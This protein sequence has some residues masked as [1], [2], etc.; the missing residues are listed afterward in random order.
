MMNLTILRWL[1]YGHRHESG[2][3]MTEFVFFLPI[4]ITVFIG[5]LNLGKVGIASTQVQ[6]QAQ[7]DL[8]AKAI[9]VSDGFQAEHMS[10][11]VAAPVTAAGY[12]ADAGETGNP[13]AGIDSLWGTLNPAFMEVRGHYGE[14]CV[15][16]KP[17]Q[18]FM[19]DGI[20]PTCS[21][22]EVLGQDDTNRYPH[23]LLNDT[24]DEVSFSGGW[25]E[26]L[27]TA[28]GMSGLIQSMAAGIRYGS[29]FGEKSET[30]EMFAGVASF[31]TSS[32]W[33]VMV[34]PRPLTGIEGDTVTFGV[35]FLAAKLDS[36]Y[37]H[38][39]QFGKTNWGGGDGTADTP[40]ADTGDI[41]DQTEE[42]I[43]EQCDS[44]P[45]YDDDPDDNPDTPP[46]PKTP[47]QEKCENR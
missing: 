31:T 1:R 46:P 4:W 30:V 8:W 42:G 40:T 32:H 25:T 16:T 33:D 41:D 24:L 26:I 20:E 12:F 45:E 17:L 5:I 10:P 29:V 21:A 13:Q 15:V 43:D 35:A 6:V 11:R 37:E 34:A 28:V 39:Q 18:P 38:Y 14:S 22:K 27:A 7:K 36:N 3:A 23:R 2:T 9:P 44:V 19:Q 47:E